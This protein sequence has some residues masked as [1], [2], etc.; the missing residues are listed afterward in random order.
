MLCRFTAVSKREWKRGD[1]RYGASWTR[2]GP[3]IE[4]LAS[5]IGAELECFVEDG[6][7]PCK[8]LRAVSSEGWQVGLEAQ[9]FS[10]SGPSLLVEFTDGACSLRQIDVALAFFGV[11]RSVVY[12]VAAEAVNA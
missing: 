4:E 5:V 11:P 8:V 6:I 10:A 3:A 1:F 2:E 12:W 7:G 9:E